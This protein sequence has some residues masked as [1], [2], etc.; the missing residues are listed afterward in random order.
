MCGAANGKHLPV[1]DS[2]VQ[3]IICGRIPG[4]VFFRAAWFDLQIFH[5]KS[6]R[7]VSAN[8]LQI[9]FSQFR[10]YSQWICYQM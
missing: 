7:K 4:I 3:G 5:V 10:N 2:T 1:K 8:A 6:V 9:F